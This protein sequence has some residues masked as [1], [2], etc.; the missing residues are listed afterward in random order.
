M[1][2]MKIKIF[3]LLYTVFLLGC[4]RG[5]QHEDV[6][7]PIKNEMVEWRLMWDALDVKLIGE[8]AV[9]ILCMKNFPVDALLCCLEDPSK[10]EVAHVLLTLRYDPEISVSYREWNGLDFWEEDEQLKMKTIQS[11]WRS[12]KERGELDKARPVREKFWRE[13]G[14]IHACPKQ[15]FK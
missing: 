1:V 11:Y 13:Y 6:V 3:V 4:V 14:V 7:L 5:G 12:K 15:L 2:Y 9:K 8:E 10:Y